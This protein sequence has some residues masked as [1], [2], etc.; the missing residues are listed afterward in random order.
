[1]PVQ[2]RSQSL[3]SAASNET[4]H[5]E[6]ETQHGLRVHRVLTSDH[7]SPAS[8][9]ATSTISDDLPP[10]Y[11]INLGLPPAQRYV[12]LATD[13]KPVIA[14]VA[15]IFDGICLNM[16]RHFP[17][18]IFKA[19]SRKCFA[20]LHSKEETEELRGISEA[21]DVEM[22]LLIALNTYLDVFMGCTSG[23]VRV[24][25]N[26]REPGMLH[27][28]TL[29]W[30]MD[31]LRKMVV[32]LDFVNEEGGDVV[33]TSIT[34]AGFVGVLTG[35]RKG[36]SLSL[37]FRPNHNVSSPL[38]HIR[39]YGHHLLVMLGFRPSI[40]S[41]LRSQLLPSDP[42]RQE[43]SSTRPRTLP[44]LES[45]ST[46][47]P[48]MTSTA[49]YLIF[50]DGKTTIAME[51]DHC[52]AAIRSTSDFVATTNHDLDHEGEGEIDDDPRL[53]EPETRVLT[54]VGESVDRKECVVERWKRDAF[55]S[56]NN[57]TLKDGDVGKGSVSQ[58][59]V[60]T[61]MG[62][63]PI[64]NECT[65]FTTLMDPKEGKVVWLKRRLEAYVQ[66]TPNNAAANNRGDTN[67]D[68]EY[69]PW[70]TATETSTPR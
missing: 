25:G 9:P 69:R 13:L 23:G 56:R 55:K 46:D 4:A 36:L 30:G 60:I 70:L 8:T 62:E 31:A 64:V 50:C 21:A 29:D 32:R 20:R 6:P 49:C 47:L 58:E 15:T 3:R 26:N 65:H 37:N 54:V 57:P 2:T 43:E 61:W 44:T 38:S 22:Y 68:I 1:M 17:V 52:T 28:R 35:V 48:A 12:K 34:Y 33:A 59:Q 45:I 5:A 39:F 18:K 19:V 14:Q 42:P 24:N 63:Y 7:A 27:F 53:M 51:K 67:G 10:T 11:T 16:H 40:S 66:I 41:I